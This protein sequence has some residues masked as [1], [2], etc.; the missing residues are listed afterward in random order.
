[1]GSTGELR[2]KREA[3]MSD[4]M[5]SPRE[6]RDPLDVEIEDLREEVARLRAELAA[7]DRHLCKTCN[8]RGWVMEY[9]SIDYGGGLGAGG[10]SN[11]PCPECKPPAVGLSAAPKEPNR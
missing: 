2:Q 8:G 7:R 1:M 9:H 3:V 4:F 5:R 6:D 11:A 10:A